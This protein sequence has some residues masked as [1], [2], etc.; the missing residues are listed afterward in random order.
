MLTQF[1]NH[2]TF[3][4]IYFWSNLGVLPFWL[5]LIF[6]P[7]SKFV[8][9]LLSIILIPTI[10]AIAYGY[11]IYQSFLLNESLF[12]VFT[13]YTSLD[14]L[15]ALFS[16]ENF[17]LIFWLHFLAINFFLGSWMSRDALRYNIKKKVVA[18]PLLFLYFFGPI[19]LI[20]YWFI[21]IFYAKK[22]NLHD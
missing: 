15:Y 11:T 7:S 8:Q 16:S 13:L 12:E 6:I 20:I 21:R 14:S 2:L 19:G 18:F 5:M 4:N 10:L 17:L 22:I 3:E 1:Y 9:F